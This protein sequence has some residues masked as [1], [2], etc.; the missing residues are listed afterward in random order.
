MYYVHV[1]VYVYV[2]VHVYVYVNQATHQSAYGA[3]FLLAFKVM[4]NGVCFMGIFPVVFHL[5]R[6]H[7]ITMQAGSFVKSYVTFGLACEQALPLKG[8]VTSQEKKSSLD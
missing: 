7:L 5:Q 2:Y 3:R 4:K 1:Y 6:Q 8:L